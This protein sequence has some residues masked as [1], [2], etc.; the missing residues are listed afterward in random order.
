[1]IGDHHSSSITVPNTTFKA[2]CD[3]RKAYNV[4]KDIVGL[5]YQSYE[6]VT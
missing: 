4:V 3:V 6:C 2:G 5:Q 1:M